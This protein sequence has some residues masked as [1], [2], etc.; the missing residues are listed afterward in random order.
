MYKLIFFGLVLIGA[1]LY[2]SGALEFDTNGDKIDVSID[3]EKAQEL[4]ESI[5]DKIQ[6]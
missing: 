5:K 2:F 4:G 1:A 3:T 6:E